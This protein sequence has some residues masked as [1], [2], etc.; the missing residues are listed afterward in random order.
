V[1]MITSS[2]LWRA[3]TT[4]MSDSEE[5]VQTAGVGPAPFFLGL[6]AFLDAAVPGHCA[7][8]SEAPGL[9]IAGR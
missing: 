5:T 1:I 6:R 4:D 7:R 8:N 9:S 3:S 2:T